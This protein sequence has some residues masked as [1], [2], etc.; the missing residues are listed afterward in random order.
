MIM[1][2]SCPR[3]SPTPTHS[4]RPQPHTHILSLPPIPPTAGA[5]VG[6]SAATA[7]VCAGAAALL[8]YCHLDR[9]LTDG[10]HKRLAKRVML[11]T[12]G[13]GE[14]AYDAGRGYYGARDR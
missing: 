11:G 5:A 14:K 13:R 12:E 3:H 1:G 10:L 7:A 2:L 8:G 9:A 6:V 4:P